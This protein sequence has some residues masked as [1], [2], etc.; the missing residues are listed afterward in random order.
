[1]PSS[2]AISRM[3]WC[4]RPSLTVWA[5]TGTKTE[6][7]PSVTSSS[8]DGMVKDWRATRTSRSASSTRCSARGA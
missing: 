5:F 3:S 6:P 2:R 8:P 7:A 4:I 1:M